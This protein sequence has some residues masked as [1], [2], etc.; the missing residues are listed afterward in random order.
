LVRRPFCH[1]FPYLLPLQVRNQYL[2][3]ERTV[4]VVAADEVDTACSIAAWLRLA[5]I[6]TFVT[7]AALEA[8]PTLAAV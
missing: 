3:S 8:R 5:F 2:E 6:H 4:A 7:V 1:R